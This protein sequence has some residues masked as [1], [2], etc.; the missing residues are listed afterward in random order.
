[1]DGSP[2]ERFFN[3]TRDTAYLC[4]SVPLWRISSVPLSLCGCSG[5]C[6]CGGFPLCL[7]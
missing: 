1:M 4:A 6:L 7:S 3:H 2:R 5:L